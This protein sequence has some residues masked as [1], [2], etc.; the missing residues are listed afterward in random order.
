MLE[1]LYHGSV[2]TAFGF[3]PR[4][5]V[6]KKSAQLAAWQRG[7]VGPPGTSRLPPDEDYIWQIELEESGSWFYDEGRV[8]VLSPG[9]S[10]DDE[11]T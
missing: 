7:P 4:G 11:D 5:P 1:F 2:P 6:A 9:S 3:Q 10:E 8:I